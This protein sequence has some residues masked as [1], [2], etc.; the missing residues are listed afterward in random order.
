MV[1]ILVYGWPAPC[2]V[3]FSVVVSPP[4]CSGQPRGSRHADTGTPHTPNIFHSFANSR[5][6]EFTDFDCVDNGVW[7]NVLKYLG[8]NCGYPWWPSCVAWWKSGLLEVYL[9]CR[10]TCHSVLVWS[11]VQHQPL[12]TTPRTK[13]QPCSASTCTLTMHICMHIKNAVDLLWVAY[14][15][16]LKVSA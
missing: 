9:Q 16:C 6:L 8:D 10:P 12:L 3:V 14:V 4:D 2:S 13:D 11:L 15:P 7:I 1:H 5:S